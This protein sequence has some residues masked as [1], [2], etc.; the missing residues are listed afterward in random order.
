[1][2][3]EKSQP[4]EAA[5]A[6][7]ATARGRLLTQLRTVGL[8]IDRSN[9]EPDTEIPELGKDMKKTIILDGIETVINVRPLEGIFANGRELCLIPTS[10]E[11]LGKILSVIERNPSRGRTLRSF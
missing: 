10:F 7:E 5:A 4:G 6:G 1:M 3:R 8:V 9:P 2:A 11:V